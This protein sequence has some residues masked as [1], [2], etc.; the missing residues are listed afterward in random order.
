MIRDLQKNMIYTL[1]SWCVMTALLMGVM[2]FTAAHK[3]I[4]IAQ[5]AQERGENVSDGAYA[6]GEKREQ[7]PL[8]AIRLTTVQQKDGEGILR[9]PLEDS[10][11]AE[12][13][14]VENRYI[15]RQ[16]WIYIQGADIDFYRTNAVVGD[17]DFLTE[18]I[19][20]IRKDGV[21]LKLETDQV[22]EYKSTLTNG[23][24]SVERFASSELYDCVIVV[25]P[26]GGGSDTG[27]VWYELSEKDITLQICNQLQKKLSSEDGI[28]VYFTRLEDVALSEQERISFAYEVGADAFLRLRVSCD[29]DHP[30][31]YGIESYYNDQF[32]QV[33]FDSAML[34]DIVTK[35]VARSSV[36]RAIG[37]LPAADES[38]LYE[39]DMAGAEICVGY[40]SNEQECELLSRESY[41]DTIAAGLAEAMSGIGS[42]V[43]E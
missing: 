14:Q 26:V 24:M 22:W 27:L 19:C 17:V 38:I 13:V 36:N 6:F 28:R 34:A 37:I 29:A 7:G 8:E 35:S 16:L 43:R 39:L 15:D 33:G 4:V 9:I 23:E 3:T 12:G 21:I 30:E 40:L 42:A 2:L 11:K 10:I 41:T 5:T 20:E 32:Y 25:D 1:V 31:L 18:A